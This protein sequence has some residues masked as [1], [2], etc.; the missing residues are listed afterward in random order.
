MEIYNLIHN[1]GRINNKRERTIKDSIREGDKRLTES[2]LFKECIYK[3][4][5]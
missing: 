1:H 5:G 4:L 3:Y 2:S